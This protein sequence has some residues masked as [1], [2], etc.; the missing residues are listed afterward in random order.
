MIAQDLKYVLLAKVPKGVSTSL[1]FDISALVQMI[2]NSEDFAEVSISVITLIEV[3]RWIENEQ[4]RLK[5]NA[6]IE[7]AFEVLDVDKEVALAYLK[8]HFELK[9]RDK[10]VSDA[11]ALIAATA[12]ARNETLSTLDK[13]FQK[14]EPVVKVKLLASSK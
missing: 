7:E 1:I 4:K 13:D 8:L 11:D 14:F 9:K 2:R 12:H 5:S 6:L 3:L 10:I